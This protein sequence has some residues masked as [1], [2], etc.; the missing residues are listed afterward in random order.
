MPV[1]KPGPQLKG[2][3]G[4]MLPWLLTLVGAILLA[5]VAFYVVRSLR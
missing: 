1:G 4:G 5:V 3:P 2:Q